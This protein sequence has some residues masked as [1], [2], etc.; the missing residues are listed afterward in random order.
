MLVLARAEPCLLKDVGAESSRDLDGPVLAE[1]VDDDDAPQLER[2]P[3]APLDVNLLVL[4]GDD[5]RQL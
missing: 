1:G 3:H 2:G 4:R 5:R